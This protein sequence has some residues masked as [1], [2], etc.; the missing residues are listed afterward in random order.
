MNQ[1]FIFIDKDISKSKYYNQVLKKK[2][3]RKCSTIIN[4]DA[5]KLV[6][7]RIL[8][9]LRETFMIEYHNR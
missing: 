3:N 1:S 4:M 9:F 2:K 5:Y 7:N 8:I 6:S